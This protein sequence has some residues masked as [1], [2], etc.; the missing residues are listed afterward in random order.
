MKWEKLVEREGDFL[1][2]HLLYENFETNFP[3]IFQRN[4]ANFLTIRQGNTFTHYWDAHDRNALARFIKNQLENDPNFMKKNVEIGKKHFQNLTAFCQDLGGLDSKSN[5]EL[6]KLAEEYF[7]LYK[8]PYPHFN[9]TVFSDELEREGNTEIINSMADWRLFA[10]DHFNKTHELV[11]PLFEEIA[12][13][14]NLTVD[15]V[16]FLKPQEIVDYLSIK[17]KI[18]N[19]HNCYFMFNEGKFQLQENES[20]VIEESFPN[21]VKGRGT[22]PAKYSGKVRVIKNNEDLK[23]VEEGE[24][25]VLRMTTPDLMLEGIKKAGAIITDEGGITCHAAVLSR[26]FNIPALMGTEVATKVFNTGDHVEVD[27]ALGVAN[28]VQ[29]QKEN[30]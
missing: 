5:E 6:G 25:L 30:R 2:N 22:F 11:N 21:E 29:P 8:E 9:L 15:E 26:E 20:Y 19:R 7:K 16:K 14:L 24:V 17:T 10:R 28:K 23:D 3:K 18:R 12:K 27:T 1:K 13:R 4:H